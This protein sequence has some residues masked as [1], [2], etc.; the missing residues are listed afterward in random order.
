MLRQ[1]AA[2]ARH[3]RTLHYNPANRDVRFQLASELVARGAHDE[4]SA[5]VER[6]LADGD[7]DAS[8]FALAGVAAFGSRQP[9]AWARGSDRLER[10][11]GRA[12]KVQI[13]DIELALARGWMGHR[14][15]TDARAALVRYL[16]TRPGSIEG[17]A[18]LARVHAELGESEIAAT[19]RRQAWARWRAQPRFER[20]TNRLWAWRVRPAVGAAQV[21]GALAGVAGTAW[22]LTRV[23]LTAPVIPQEDEPPRRLFGEAA[24]VHE[25]A[26]IDLHQWPARD[27][28]VPRVTPAPAPDRFDARTVRRSSG[29]PTLVRHR[30]D[31]DNDGALDQRRKSVAADFVCRVPE[32]LGRPVVGSDAWIVRDTVTDAEIYAMFDALEVI[33]LVHAEDEA[34]A[35]QSVLAFEQ[36]IEDQPL[37]DCVVAL[38]RWPEGNI[39]VAQGRPFADALTEADRSV[40]FED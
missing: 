30:L 1:R 29:P 31:L 16:D 15:W 27:W 2:I 37:R 25:Y 17:L 21:G 39:G 9:D 7:D 20:R 40:Y 11:R 32:S 28:S 12:T 22:L 38:Q 36:M 4:A 18:R 33:Y 35:E 34:T 14:R 5:L 23:S 19:T 3:R 24:I 6:N 13:S 8:T 10:A 26:E